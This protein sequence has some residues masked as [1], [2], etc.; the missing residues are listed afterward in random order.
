MTKNVRETTI[1]NYRGPRGEGLPHR[2]ARLNSLL[3]Q[4]TGLQFGAVD[5]MLACLRA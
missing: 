4:V 1:S 3:T 2:S 5:V